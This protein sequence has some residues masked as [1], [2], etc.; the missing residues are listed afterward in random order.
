MARLDIV[1]KC[2]L[3]VCLCSPKADEITCSANLLVRVDD[4]N[5]VYASVTD[6]PNRNIIR[7]SSTAAALT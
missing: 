4:A 3:F 7:V 1:R 6:E 2:R 5:K